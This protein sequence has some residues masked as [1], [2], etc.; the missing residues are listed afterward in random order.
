MRNRT[1]R[2]KII[3]RCRISPEKFWR[4]ITEI[5]INLYIFAGSALF[6]VE[7]RETIWPRILS[8]NILPPKYHYRLMKKKTCAIRVSPFVMENM[9]LQKISRKKF[10][11][12]LSTKYERC[13]KNGM[14][15]IRKRN[16][17]R[18]NDIS[19]SRRKIATWRLWVPAADRHP[20]NNVNLA[21]LQTDKSDTLDERPNLDISVYTHF[22]LRASLRNTQTTA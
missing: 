6:H 15:S 8:K 18:D 9:R 22:A 14:P 4:I 5:Y 2:L 1:K 19:Q 17:S 11:R 10:Y 20:D 13:A 16:L 12:N 3:A 21:W 7:Y